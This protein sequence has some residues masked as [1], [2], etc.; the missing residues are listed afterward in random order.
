MK[1]H[2][3]FKLRKTET[4]K[5]FHLYI[6]GFDIAGFKQKNI[7]KIRYMSSLCCFSLYKQYMA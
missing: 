2:F 3:I 4:E 6:V 1:K 7:L 5:Q